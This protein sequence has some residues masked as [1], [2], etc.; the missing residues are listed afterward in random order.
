MTISHV[1]PDCFDVAFKRGSKLMTESRKHWRKWKQK[2]KKLEWQVSQTDKH[3]SKQ[4]W[5]CPIVRVNKYVPVLRYYVG[6]R[7]LGH[8]IWPHHI[9]TGNLNSCS[10]VCM[11]LHVCVSPKGI[12]TLHHLVISQLSHLINTASLIVLCQTLFSLSEF[13]K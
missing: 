13:G 4:T 3:T 1:G 9:V 5:R 12:M 8:E 11:R 10:C 2:S 7:L 6:V